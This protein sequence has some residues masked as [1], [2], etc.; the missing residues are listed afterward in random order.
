MLDDLEFAFFMLLLPAFLWIQPKTRRDG[1]NWIIA[2]KTVPPGIL[3]CCWSGQLLLVIWNALRDRLER[4]IVLPLWGVF[5]LPLIAGLLF[6]M[7]AGFIIKRKSAPPGEKYRPGPS[8]ALF[9]ILL[10]PSLV[11]Y[12]VISFV[13][14]MAGI[15]KYRSE[16][17][18]RRLPAEGDTKIVFQEQSIHPFLAEYDYRIRFS[19]GDWLTYKLLFTNPGGNTYFNLY[20]LKDGRLLFRDKHWDYLVD[21]A[22]QQVFVLKKFERKLYAAKLP[23]EKVTSWPN[24]VREKGQV[25][26]KFGNRTLPAE[27]VTGLLDGM[28]YYGCITTRFRSAAQEPEQAIRFHPNESRL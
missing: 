25:V 24:P 19:R 13:S 21:P 5:G 3:V 11:L 27:E 20:R 7:L 17:R 6:T 18:S 12:S 28:T 9:A 22:A 2:L 10:P 8:V 14:S 16:W 26:M 15:E 23:D 4:D 1:R